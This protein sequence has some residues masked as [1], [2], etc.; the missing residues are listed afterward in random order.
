MPK[1]KGNYCNVEGCHNRSQTD[2]E[3]KK[4]YY[5]LPA[6]IRNQGKE[7]ENL[8]SDRRRLWLSKLNQNMDGKNLSNVRICSEHFINKKKAELY[9]KNSPDW[10]P[11]VDMSKA[12]TEKPDSKSPAANKR[13]QRKVDRAEKCDAANTLLEL[14]TMFETD[15][16]DDS[17]CVSD[18]E[19]GT[20]IQTDIDQPLF[21]AMHE[22][23][24]SLRTEN[25]TLSRQ[26]CSASSQFKVF[27]FEGDD[28]KVKYFTGLPKFTLLIS[29]F[30][31]LESCLPMKQSLDKFQILILC[32]MRLRLNLSLQLLAYQFNVSQSTVARYFAETISVMYIK[33]KPLVSWPERDELIKTMPMQFRKHLGTKV[34]I[35]IDCFEIFIDRPSNVLARAQTWS[36]YKHHNTAKYLIDIT[37]QGSISFIS[38]GWG[39]RVSDKYITENCSFLSHV[40]PGDIIMADRGFDIS[41]TLGSVCAEARIP[42]FTKRKKPT[43]TTRC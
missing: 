9:Q 2:K 22:E 7:C 34:A 41:D 3:N 11:T 12:A 36:S 26:I 43:V 30:H 18:A 29:I 10:I 42:A 6:V 25:V 23:L 35:I 27:E 31:F 32:L 24:Q 1:V 15:A 4:H 38:L 39:G 19:T 40:L 8:S 37:P 5:R 20:A 33:M 28:E 21:S 14:N 16:H 17:D 13:Y